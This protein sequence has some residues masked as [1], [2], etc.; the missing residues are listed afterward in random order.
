M[1]DPFDSS[2]QKLARADKHFVE[3]QRE[4]TVFNNLQPYERVVEA[5]PDKPGHTVEKIRMTQPI[6]AGIADNAADIAIS[7]RSALDNAGYTIAVAAGVKVPKRCAFPFAGCVAKMP[8]AL[9][10][11]KDIPEKIH[12]LFC[13]FQPYKGGNDLLWALNELANTDKHKMVIPVGQALA[14]HGVNVRGT[15]FFS[16]PDPHVWD[17]AKNEMKLI[18]LGLGA[19]YQYDFQFRFFIA[20][21][22]IEII[23]GQS[24]VRIL[25]DMGGIVERVLVG[26]E[27]ESRRLGIV[28]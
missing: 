12:S 13:G 6:P 22:D 18:E 25:H 27:A 3:L 20:F 21:H 9:G 26:I 17:R 19:T 28:K 16:M 7:L 8:S 24:I 2:H 23:D 15:G 11:C 1:S 14:R 4:I 5:H 10:R